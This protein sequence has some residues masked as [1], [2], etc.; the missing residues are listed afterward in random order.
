MG[1]FE[2]T[3]MILATV[4]SQGMPSARV[5]LLKEFDDRG[6]CFFTN[7]ESEKGK[8]LKAHPQGA[9]VF[10]WEKPLHR[11]IRVRGTFE[12]MSYEQSNAYFQTRPRGSQIGAWSSPQSQVIQSRDELKQSVQAIE[13]RFKGGE[14][15]C[16]ENWGGYRL[17]P[18]SFEFWQAQ[19]FRLHD[20]MKFSRSKP[21]GPWIAQRLAP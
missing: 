12:K 1:N 3:A 5:V 18:L 7:Y 13:E 9:L 6:L 21:S 19:E 11:Q 10:H 15:P 17:Q 20:R 2:P 14:I 4:D 16:P 8:E